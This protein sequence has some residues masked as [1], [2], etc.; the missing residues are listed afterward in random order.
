MMGRRRSSNLTGH[1]LESDGDYI[2]ID[3]DGDDLYLDDE[4]NRRRWETITASAPNACDQLLPVRALF[5]R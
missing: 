4:P 3:V 2:S 1:Y 5:V